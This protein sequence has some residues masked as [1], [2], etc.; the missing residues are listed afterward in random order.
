MLVLGEI[1]AQDDKRDSLGSLLGHHFK[2]RP[3]AFLNERARVV[4]G[5][6]DTSTGTVTPER[7]VNTG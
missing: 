3:F 1:D 5:S 2:N 4:A 6:F 7:S